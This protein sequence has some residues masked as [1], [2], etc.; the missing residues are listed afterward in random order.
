MDGKNSHYS[1]THF[2]GDIV[3]KESSNYR[4]EKTV[5]AVGNV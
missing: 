4:H 2:T 3:Y 1:L 5:D